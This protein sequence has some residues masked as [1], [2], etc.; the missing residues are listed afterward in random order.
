MSTITGQCP[1]CGRPTEPAV[2]FSKG[3]ERTPWVRHRGGSAWC[4]DG[5]GRYYSSGTTAPQ[6]GP[7]MAAAVA[8][9]GAGTLASCEQAIAAEELFRVNG[10]WYGTLAAA[11]AARSAP[12]SL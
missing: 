8:L 6:E 4:Q 2:Y 7:V 5:E 10:Q 1:H 11:N 3:Q 12:G 9:A